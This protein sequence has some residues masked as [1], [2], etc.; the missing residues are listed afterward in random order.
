MSTEP[1]MEGGVKVAARDRADVSDVRRR[2][3]RAIVVTN[4][5]LLSRLDDELRDGTEVDLQTYDALLHVFEA[6]P[7]GAR[8]TDLARAVVLTKAGLTSLVDRLESRGL[9]AR[10]ADPTDR[11]VSRIVL[12]DEGVAV[13][14]A[15]AEVHVAGI[16]QHFTD[17]ITDAEA[18]VIVDALERVD[19]Q[20]R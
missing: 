12:T 20:E 6:G 18:Q 3:W 5:L 19:R 7:D 16:R 9:V 2:A 8:M 1:Q 10:R 15:A 13:F 4:G 17:R 11:R 14:R